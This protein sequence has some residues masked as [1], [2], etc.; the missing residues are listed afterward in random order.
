MKQLALVYS[1]IYI[2][3]L[4][5]NSGGKTHTYTHTHTREFYSFYAF[6]SGRDLGGE[7]VGESLESKILG[8]KKNAGS[9]SRPK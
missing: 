1:L 8:T 9:S 3:L 6:V 7:K 2:L 4:L 5:K